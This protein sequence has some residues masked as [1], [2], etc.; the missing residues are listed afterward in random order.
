MS[1]IFT[2][3]FSDSFHRAN[4]NPLSDGG[5]WTLIDGDSPA[6]VINDS[7]EPTVTQLTCGAIWTGSG[8]TW[9]SNP[10][11]SLTVNSLVAADAELEFNLYLR[12][13]ND[14]TFSS[15]YDFVYNQE[16]Y[17]LV[18]L[19]TET[20]IVVAPLVVSAGDVV[21]FG[22]FNNTWLVYHNGV[23]LNSGINSSTPSG[24]FGGFDI[25]A[26]VVSNI[27]LSNVSGGTVT[28]NSGAGANSLN[29]AMDASLRNSGLRH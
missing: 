5:N 8:F 29:L 15:G 9:P 3:Q 16:E 28:Q 26:S 6:Q 22:I 1:F 11:A 25:A 27:S 2:P 19:K 18:D 23:L 10:W 13:T 17:A 24:G 7:C 14:G 21:L 12:L 4:E 20:E